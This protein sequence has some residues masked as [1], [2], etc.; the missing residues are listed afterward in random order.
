MQSVAFTRDESSP[1]DEA[2]EKPLDPRYIVE[3]YISQ[4]P[5]VEAKDSLSQVRNVAYFDAGLA[6]SLIH[7]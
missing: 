1:E 6:L 2:E 7:I 5:S 4:I 3:T